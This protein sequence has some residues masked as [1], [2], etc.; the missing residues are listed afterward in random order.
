M[1]IYL[2]G[3]LNIYNHSNFICA[4]SLKQTKFLIK[5]ALWQGHYKNNVS[6]GNK[7]NLKKQICK[8][9]TAIICANSKSKDYRKI[10]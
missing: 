1:Y 10:N 7:K 6:F 3:K 4:Y 5:N 2:L 8:Y 9:I